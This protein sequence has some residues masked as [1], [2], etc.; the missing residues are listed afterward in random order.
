MQF[1][2]AFLSL[3]LMA[4]PSSAQFDFDKTEK[5]TIWNTF[6][7]EEST[8]G[9]EFIYFKAEAEIMSGGD[10]E[11]TLFPPNPP[12]TTEGGFYDINIDF[13]DQGKEGTI[14]WTLKDNTGAGHLVFD[15]GSYDRYYL[16][17]EKPI[18]SATVESSDSIVVETGVPLYEERV[19]VDGFG[20]GLEFP[21][22]LDYKC[23]K[24]FVKPKTNLTELEQ[25]IV[26]KVSRKKDKGFDKEWNG[27]GIFDFIKELFGLD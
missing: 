6:Q 16:F 27:F 21:E 7:E 18:F 14:T 20:T 10:P 9:D 2:S 13:D 26:V 5:V 24:M 3:A 8:G 17:F 25:Q 11:F 4:T 1:Y 23:L 15:E 19:L 12:N 22:V